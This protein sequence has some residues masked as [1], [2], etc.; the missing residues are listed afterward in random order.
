MQTFHENPVRIVPMNKPSSRQLAYFSFWR[1]CGW[2][3]IALVI[4]L[5]LTPSPPDLPGEQGDKV[6]H[7]LAYGTL[8]IWF[9]WLYPGLRR[10]GACAIGFIALGVV[11][12]FAQGESGY[13]TFDLLDMA[14][15]A[16]GVGLGWIGALLPLPSGPRVLE[17]FIRRIKG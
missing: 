2:G 7:A 9:A 1:A 16:L 8:M 6:G 4:Y 3:L 12:E 5:S 11:L 15:D 14:A 10:R 17:A 13:R